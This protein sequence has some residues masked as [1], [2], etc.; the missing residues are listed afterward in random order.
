MHYHGPV[1]AGFCFMYRELSG[2]VVAELFAD[3]FAVHVG[4]AVF[5]YTARV[6][7]APDSVTL[8]LVVVG[9]KLP[10]SFACHSAAHAVW[11]ETAACAKSRIA[12]A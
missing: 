1:L 3:A 2:A 6:P 12:I 8:G 7:V 10:E 5:Q 9:I 4:K 11:I